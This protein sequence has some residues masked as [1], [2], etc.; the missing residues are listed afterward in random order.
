[1]LDLTLEGHSQIAKVV[2]C[3]LVIE[4]K[5]RI[6]FLISDLGQEQVEV[7]VKFGVNLS[8]FIKS[9]CALYL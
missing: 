9:K 4:T 1:M 7:T 6:C 5:T 3:F 8:P 2:A